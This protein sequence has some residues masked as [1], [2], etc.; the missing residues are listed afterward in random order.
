M[1]M[2][3]EQHT[4]RVEFSGFSHADSLKS[5]ISIAIDNE[6][7]VIVEHRISPVPGK[8]GAGAETYLLKVFTDGESTYMNAVI[9]HGCK[10]L[11]I[12]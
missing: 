11:G 8:A 6:C 4:D 3:V 9:E 1:T 10:L 7:D 5:L 12:K 2:H